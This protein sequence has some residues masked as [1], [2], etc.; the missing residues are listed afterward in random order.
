MSEFAIF[1]QKRAEVAPQ[2]KV[3][4][5]FFWSLGRVK[6]SRSILLY[7]V[8]ELAG[9]GSLALAFGVSDR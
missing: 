6:I 1:A 2:K 8:G 5:E 7:I 9:G 4:L 3:D